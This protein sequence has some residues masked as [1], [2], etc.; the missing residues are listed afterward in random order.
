MKTI[1][2]VSGVIVALCFV[3][4]GEMLIDAW[5]EIDSLRK[6]IERLKTNKKNGDNNYTDNIVE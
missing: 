3:A 6:K 1:L 2:L 5:R 4:L